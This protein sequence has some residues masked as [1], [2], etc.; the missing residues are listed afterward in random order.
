MKTSSFRE[1]R[2]LLVLVL[3]GAIVAVWFSPL[4][5]PA[6]ESL[7]AGTKRAFVTFASARALNGVV[8]EVDDLI[9][10]AVMMPGEDGL[11]LTRHLVETQDIPVILLTA[12]YTWMERRQAALMQDR[13]GPTRAHIPL[14]GKKINLWG[15]VHIAADGLK[16]GTLQRG[17]LLC[18]DQREVQQAIEGLAHPVVVQGLERLGIR[19]LA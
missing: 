1:R 17:S 19:D 3:L 18:T 8:D 16:F 15:M 12:I 5:H 10:L 2:V 11:S 7:D 14:G 13:I 9:V 4:D 6:S